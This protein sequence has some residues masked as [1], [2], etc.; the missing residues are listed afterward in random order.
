MIRESHLNFL[1]SNNLR[2]TQGSND[3][4]LTEE[5]FFNSIMK[6]HIG[7]IS[8]KKNALKNT[9]LNNLDDILPPIEEEK[10]VAPPKRRINFSEYREIATSKIGG[11]GTSNIGKI[12]GSRMQ[13]IAEVSDYLEAEEANLFMDSEYPMIEE[14]LVI[15][16][17]VGA[18]QKNLLNG[19]SCFCC[20]KS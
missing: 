13:D 17:F 12:T 6:S 8:G 11:R 2:A 19:Q 3:L 16:S 5:I 15:K 14:T 18:N 1:G 10:K 7:Q 20:C 9:N 4:K